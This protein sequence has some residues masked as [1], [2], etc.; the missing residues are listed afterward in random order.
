[1]AR[2]VWLLR[3]PIA[4]L[5]TVQAPLW[6]IRY[7]PDLLTPRMPICNT[8]AD[9]VVNM[10]ELQR[11]NIQFGGNRADVS[12][13]V[14]CRPSANAG[15][16]RRSG[17]SYMLYMLL[18]REVIK[19]CFT[20]YNIYMGESYTTHHTSSLNKVRKML[21]ISAKTLH[22]QGDSNMSGTDL[23]VNKP[24]WHVQVSVWQLWFKKKNQSRSYLNHLVFSHIRPT[25]ATLPW[26]R[27]WI[28]L[29]KPLLVS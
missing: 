16:G 21:K 1:M 29:G 22:I 7:V 6:A 2:Q 9:L 15:R 26:T 18:W 28:L 4:S 24:H 20:Y 27:N 10:L 14:R 13:T 5:Y 11:G 23:C 3:R 25:T 8:W 17:H 12:A 19:G